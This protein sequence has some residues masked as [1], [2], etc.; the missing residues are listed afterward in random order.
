MAHGFLHEGPPRRKSIRFR[1]CPSTREGTRSLR[2]IAGGVA[3]VLV[4]A[5]FSA[6]T[7][8][9]AMV[10]PVSLLGVGALIGLLLVIAGGALALAAI[11]RQGE[12]SI[13]VLATLPIWVLAVFLV[14]G[15]LFLWE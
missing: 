9:H 11:I 1:G 12:R 15:E 6:S 7:D 2:L 14:V 4:L 13:F 10:G 3:V 5:L 8:I